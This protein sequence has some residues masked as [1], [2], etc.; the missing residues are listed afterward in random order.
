[1]K[2]Q[3][4]IFDEIEIDESKKLIFEQGVIGY[5]DFK[6]FF[7]LCDAEREAESTIRWLQS[8]DD[9][10]FALPVIDPLLIRE[11]YNPS[12]EDEI[13]ASLGDINSEFVVFTTIRVPSDITQMTVNLK[14]PIIVNADTQKGCQVIVEAEGCDVRVPVY[15]I[16]KSRKE[17]KT[18]NQGCG[19]QQKRG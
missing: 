2:L 1:M 12:V 8:A 18:E 13:L 14:A 19:G 17:V 4:R 11:D 6:E 15:E 16:L 3:T 7:L 10:C 9:P 5:P